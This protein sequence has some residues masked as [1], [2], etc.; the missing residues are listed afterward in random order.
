MIFDTFPDNPE[1]YNP[2]LRP[3][4]T[5]TIE[6]FGKDEWRA[7]I[8]TTEM[9]GH[10]GIYAIIGVKMGIMALE[11]LGADSGGVSIISFAGIVPPVS[12]LNDGLQVS[13]E[14]TLG[15]GLISS[16]PTSSP[17][18]KVIFSTGNKSLELRLRED[19]SA[20]VKGEIANAVE[21]YGYSPA[22]WDYVRKL[23]V[24]YWH[25]LDRR[26]IFDIIDNTK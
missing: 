13:T 22:Y 19:V 8:L 4:V 17:E 10:L 21:K 14:A 9:H 7:A 25:E 18:V 16:P 11:Y 20:M 12:C 5:E 15:H 23:A 6:R 2:D 3:I 24:R 26:E 1:L